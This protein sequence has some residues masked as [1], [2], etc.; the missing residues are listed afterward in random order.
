MRVEDLEAPL[1]FPLKRLLIRISAASSN[2][3]FATV[4]LLNTMVTR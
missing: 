1:L 3:S 2:G 4:A